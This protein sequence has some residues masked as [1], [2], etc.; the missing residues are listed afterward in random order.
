[1]DFL[2]NNKHKEGRRE[3]GYV[4]Q[5][6]FFNFRAGK[7]LAVCISPHGECRVGDSIYDTKIAQKALTMS[8]DKYAEIAG[9][10]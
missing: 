9:K 5:S 2:C 7:P 3:F 10:I 1:M 6:F 4:G 8:I